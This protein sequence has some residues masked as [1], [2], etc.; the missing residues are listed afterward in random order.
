MKGL[1]ILIIALMASVA[2]IHGAVLSFD[3]DVD[4][5]GEVDSLTDG[6]L[7]LRY[8]FGFRGATL[9]VGAVGVNCARCDATAIE[10]HFA[11]LDVRLDIDGSGVVDPLTDGVLALRYL[12]GFRGAILVSG[13]VSPDCA[14]CTAV[15]I[16]AYLAGLGLFAAYDD[17]YRWLDTIT[18]NA[19]FWR[20]DSTYH[21]ALTPEAA[22]GVL[23]NDAGSGL[24]VE[25]V[26]DPNLATYNPDGSPLGTLSNV[27][28]QFSLSPDGSF[29]L[30]HDIF[31]LDLGIL[32]FFEG[33]TKFQYKLTDQAGNDILDENLEPITAWATIQII[34]DTSGVA[35]Q[36]QAGMESFLEESTVEDGNLVTVQGSIPLGLQ[37][38]VLAVTIVPNLIT[39]PNLVTYTVQ[40]PDPTYFLTFTT[41]LPL[42]TAGNA[43]PSERTFAQAT[44]VYCCSVPVVAGACSGNAAIIT[45]TESLQV[46]GCDQERCKGAFGQ[47]HS[48]R[49]IAYEC[50]FRFYHIGGDNGFCMRDY[51]NI[52]DALFWA[53]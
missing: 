25:L 49:I 46:T 4:A 38:P 35:T 50:P 45:Q 14:E 36:Y 53:H 26:S 21:P 11:S 13:A 44:T 39:L 47:F 3:L 15:E 23:R 9:I 24:R 22:E 43:C 5:D 30:T 51:A 42:V 52:Y 10:A 34:P 32:Q 16:E 18:N 1:V 12:F 19:L 29:V 40:P 33:Y 28:M 37:M 7:A 6:V 8:S 20:F 2:P 17:N 31:S 41:S 48:V 27:L